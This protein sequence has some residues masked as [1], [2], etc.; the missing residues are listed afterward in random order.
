MLIYGIINHRQQ[1][2]KDTAAIKLIIFGKDN[3]QINKL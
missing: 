1:Y 3:I 2:T